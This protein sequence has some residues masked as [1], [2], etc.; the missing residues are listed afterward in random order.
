MKKVIV[1]LALILMAGSMFAQELENDS[2]R[3]WRNFETN[4]LVD[5]WELSIGA[6]INTFYLMKWSDY[7][8]HQLNPEGFGKDITLLPIDVTIGKWFT[9]HIGFRGVFTFEGLVDNLRNYPAV[10]IGEGTPPIGEY[11]YWALH[12]DVMLN[13][14]N[15]ICRY[16]AD[17][18]YNAIL[19]AG[20]GYSR[21]EVI[22]DGIQ[23]MPNAHRKEFTLY[24]GLI[25]R[26]RL[27]DAWAVNIEVRDQVS[28]PFLLAYN[29]T[30]EHQLPNRHIYGN[31]LSATA[32][33]TWKFSKVR[34]FKTIDRPFYE[35]QISGLE[36]DLQDANDQ[37]AEYQRQVEK[38]KK[39][40]SEK[41][42][43]L[44]EKNKE[45]QEALRKLAET[46]DK[47]M[48]L[49]DDV[50]LSIFFTIGSAKISE[51][52]MININYIADIIKASDR[53]YT[54]TG[55][56][57]KETGTPEFNLKLSQQR[58]EAVYNALID[59]GV[60]SSKLNI[61]YKGCTV[62]PF[63]KNYLNRVAVIN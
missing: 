54:I 51:K 36:K 53:S 50:T 52:N 37:N 25:N 10:W 56:A 27:S 6:G 30:R 16:K 32:G 15:W 33:L 29:D 2:K 58:A 1:T 41:D 49:E 47:K 26:L 21:A 63:D 48:N 60:D 14:T 22:D 5:N 13:L 40:L 61:D 23:Y 19:F 17:R 42:R 18:F 44:S 46:Q 39:Q 4:R 3:R 28:R 8:L 57:D 45:L 38:Y 12:A 62:Q 20:A 55:Y 35:N 43:E 7:D 11:Q 59:A 24:F 9:P 31:L 34:D